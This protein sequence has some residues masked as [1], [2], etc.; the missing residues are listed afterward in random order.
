MAQTDLLRIGGSSGLTQPTPIVALGMSLNGAFIVTGDEN[1]RARVFDVAQN[2]QISEL[3]LPGDIN[4][5]DRCIK[6]V[7]VSDNGR[8]ALIHIRG[9]DRMFL[10]RTS[11]GSVTQL[12]GWGSSPRAVL[13]P[14]GAWTAQVAISVYTWKS[15][16]QMTEYWEPNS[17][18]TDLAVNSKGLVAIVFSR[19]TDGKFK[20]RPPGV[21]RFQTKEGRKVGTLEVDEAFGSARCGF[22]NDQ[23]LLIITKSKAIHVDVKQKKVVSTKKHALEDMSYQGE[24]LGPLGLVMLHG[25]LLDPTTGKQRGEGSAWA[26]S[27]DGTSLI[28]AFGAAIVRRDPQTLEEVGATGAMRGRV[29]AIAFEPD[30]QALWSGDAEGIRRWKLPSGEADVVMKPPKGTVP[31]ALSSD[32]RTLVLSSATAFLKMDLPLGRVSTAKMTPSSRMFGFS[33]D[34]KWLSIAKSKNELQVYDVAKGKLVRTR[35]FGNERYVY[36]SAFTSKGEVLSGCGDSRIH[37]LDAKKPT[38]FRVP[39]AGRPPLGMDIAPDGTWLVMG[40]DSAVVSVHELPSGKLRHQLKV[41]HKTV[42]K[43][44]ISP[45]GKRIAATDEHQVSVWNARSGKRLQVVPVA[46]ES[47]AFSADSKRIAA[48]CNGEIFVFDVSVG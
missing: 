47:L 48:G 1:G 19:G 5:F 4:R 44:L 31:V 33:R 18:A 12:T 23:T 36:A 26:A 27:S 35:S 14:D 22:L 17:G 28:S 3:K 37:L 2:A 16:Q 39:Q 45:D 8:I 9:H 38:A 13:C 20:G 34:G 41:K 46:A 15:T 32:A 30:G 7:H 43:V 21:V 10:G 25:K 29:R 42:W 24:V 40:C 6:R 11:D